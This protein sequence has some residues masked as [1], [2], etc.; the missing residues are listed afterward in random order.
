CQACVSWLKALDRRGR[1]DPRPIDGAELLRV[2]PSVSLED[3]LRELHVVTPGGEVLR[4][5]S[6]V[7]RLARLFPATWLVGAA[8]TVPPVSWL[9]NA[10]SGFVARNRYALS[11]CR[12]GACR[13]ARPA[14]VRKRSRL[15]AFWSC[16][17][18]GMLLRLPLSA[19]IVARS[20]FTSAAHYA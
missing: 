13:V 3:S 8:G 4:G 10:M 20:T 5:W 11:K 14:E 6:A 12:G 1:T 15:G 19:G 16:Y 7:A 17:T 9:A 18:T 2:C